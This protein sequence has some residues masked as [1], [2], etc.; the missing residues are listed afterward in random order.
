MKYNFLN[1]GKKLTPD[2]IKGQMNFDHVVKGASIWTGFKLGSGLLKLGTDFSTSFV[3]GASAVV[4]TTAAMVT[5]N[6]GVFSAKTSDISDPEPL[7]ESV[8]VTADSTTSLADILK[9]KSLDSLV[10]MKRLISQS[11]LGQLSASQ[12]AIIQVPTQPVE[13][14]SIHQVDVKTKARPL[15]DFGSFKAFIDT[16][17]NYPIDP[18]TVSV[19]G[20]N[21]DATP[22]QEGYVQVFWTINKQGNAKNFKIMKSLGEA[23]DNEAIRV[24]KSYKNWEPASYNGEAVESNLTLKVYFNTN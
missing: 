1:K 16:E 14:D 4:I 21:A 10:K 12:K 23:F 7:E 18:I 6:S 22:Q 13:V 8:L 2:D 19:N 20:N 17:L 24:I 3:V 5:I 15:P 11:R 9:S